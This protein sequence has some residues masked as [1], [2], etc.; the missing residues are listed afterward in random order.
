LSRVADPRF[1]LMSGSGE[2][3][4]ERAVIETS[5]VIEHIVSI[6]ELQPIETNH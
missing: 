3:V 5:N 4:G 6:S 2:D 1:A